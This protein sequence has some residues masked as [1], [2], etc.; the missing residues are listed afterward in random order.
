MARRRYLI[1][2]GWQNRRPQG[3]WQWWLADRLRA[4]GH[5]VC[6]PQLPDPE[7]PVLQRWLTEIEA[8]LERDA[9]T[10]QVV[11][12]HSLACAAWIHL[13]ESSQSVHLRVA[14]LLFVAPPSPAFLAEHDELSDFPFT[15]EAAKAVADTCRST[16]RLAYAENDPY[17]RPPASELYRGFDADLLTGAGH[18]DLAAGYGRWESALAWC[19]DP[20]ARLT[21]H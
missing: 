8:S 6:Y 18:I 3:H 1:L 11:L 14:E 15:T 19:L 21:T 16:P 13:A 5:D 17:C 7:R 10:E 12:A 2:H 9:G 4:R 20:A